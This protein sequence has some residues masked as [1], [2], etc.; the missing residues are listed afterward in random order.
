MNIIDIENK[1]REL[2]SNLKNGDSNRLRL[3]LLND[4][5]LQLFEFKD[6][7]VIDSYLLE[8]SE[9]YIYSLSNWNVFFLPPA[10][11]ARVIKL[12]EQ[13]KAQPAF[14]PFK[15]N[16][17]LIIPKLENS[18]QELEEILR[19]EYSAKIP[20]KSKISFPVIEESVSADR[21]VLYG[22]VESITVHIDKGTTKDKFIIVPSLPAIEEKL[23]KQ[24]KISWNKALEIVKRYKRRVNNYHDIIINF[25]ERL[26]EYAGN[27]L[28]I[29]L[30]LAF[31]Q[32]LFVFYN[33]PIK[34]RV[35]ED[36]A[37]TGGLDEN[38]KVIPLKNNAYIKTKIGSIF[39]S[40]INKII[41]HRDD[42]EVAKTELNKLLL[43]YP[44]RKLKL[45]GVEDFDD[46]MNRRDIVEI[47]KQNIALR[48]YIF[49]RQH[50][51]SLVVLIIA[52]LSVVYI[53]MDFNTNPDY[54]TNV[55]RIV[56]VHNN[57]GRILWQKR[58]F[59][60][61][62]SKDFNRQS[63]QLYERV[64][65]INNDNYNEVLLAAYSLHE[66]ARNFANYV[67]CF[68]H[69]GSLM[70]K[71]SFQDSVATSRDQHTIVYESAIIDTLTE[72]GR[73]NVLLYARNDPN[74]PSA[75]YRLDAETGKRLP[76]TFWHPGHICGV[77]L[78]DFNHS[79]KKE[80]VAVA[81][82][83]CYETCALFSIDVDNIGGQAPSFGGYKF[84]GIPPAKLNKY[85]L[86]PKTDLTE[87]YKLRFN[88]V[89][90]GG[91]FFN[92]RDNNFRFI[93]GEGDPSK[94]DT[95]IEY[96]VSSKL[97]DFRI[98]ISDKFQVIRDSLVSKGLL[99]KPYSNTEEYI[100]ILK[101]QIK[102]WNGKG[103]S[104][105]Y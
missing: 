20:E 85:F 79:G 26:G 98:F 62:R 21:N 14:S 103:F 38:G 54:L 76:G 32:E 9:K 94:Y 90:R 53:N 42:E 8:F 40:N 18:L 60:S 39:Y 68:D 88:T 70:W 10:E 35:A 11:T 69:K 83:N 86:L 101:K 45:I 25:D 29:A 37:F 50:K 55:N 104:S 22:F 44:E 23:E 49:S 73:L 33:T 58:I 56:C 17:S 72:N 87:Y 6:Q 67:A 102:V 46:L 78:G 63:R 96:I 84:I 57:R 15:E 7:N 13:I 4:F 61:T 64:I 59:Q 100:D 82:N 48:A 93:I 31:L 99:S 95:G 34:L 47:K 52:V 1:R 2:L 80:I 81:I 30:V 74:Y 65:N 24:I 3:L 19:G 5:F 92:N 43:K 12:A 105:V 91:I 16:L 89:G 28:G 27:S 77:A 66:G 36:I 51:F 75:I 41:L 97:S 71:Y